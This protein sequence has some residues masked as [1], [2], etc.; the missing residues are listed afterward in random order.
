MGQI[1]TQLNE[2]QL[3]QAHSLYLKIRFFLMRKILIEAI[4]LLLV[5]SEMSFM[6]L[7]FGLPLSLGAGGASVSQISE[8]FHLFFYVAILYG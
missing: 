4:P 7:S 1:E 8:E 2:R 6:K 3:Y 5:L